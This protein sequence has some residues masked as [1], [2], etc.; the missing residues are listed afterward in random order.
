MFLAVCARDIY[1][2]MITFVQSCVFVMKLCLFVRFTVF[3]RGMLHIQTIYSFCLKAS[4]AAQ[5]VTL[6]GHKNEFMNLWSYLI[7]SFHLGYAVICLFVLLKGTCNY[8]QRNLIETQVLRYWFKFFNL[9]NLLRLLP[10]N[11]SAPN[12]D[13]PQRRF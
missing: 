3:G 7:D 1:P 9:R 4:N 13:L 5:I 10:K 12:P 11:L 2:P 6:V 8:L